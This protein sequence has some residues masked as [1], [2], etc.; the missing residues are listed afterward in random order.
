MSFKPQLP[1]EF[2]IDLIRYGVVSLR[3]S[4]PRGIRLI[5]VDLALE[6]N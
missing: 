2:R 4:T 1:A 3:T 5:S 6:R